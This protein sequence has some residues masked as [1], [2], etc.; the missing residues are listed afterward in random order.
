[1]EQ[2][3]PAGLGKGQTSEFIENDEVACEGFERTMSAK[4]TTDW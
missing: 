2:Q 4:G 3:L 1:M